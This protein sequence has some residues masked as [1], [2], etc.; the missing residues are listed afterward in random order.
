MLRGVGSLE[1]AWDR[2]G[3]TGR[4][5]ALLEVLDINGKAVSV[6]CRT[7]EYLSFIFL[8]LSTHKGK[9][10]SKKH[11]PGIFP[12]RDSLQYYYSSPWRKNIIKK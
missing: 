5:S 6:P 2:E 1:E 4:G 12:G 9:T 3:F 7:A 8:L 10:M 11:A